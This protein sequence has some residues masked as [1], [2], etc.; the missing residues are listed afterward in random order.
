[1]LWELG[2]F[3]KLVER[4]NLKISKVKKQEENKETIFTT[5]Y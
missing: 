2:K 3:E 1:M 5:A 4:I